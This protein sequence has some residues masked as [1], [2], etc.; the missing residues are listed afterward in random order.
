MDSRNVADDLEPAGFYRTE[1]PDIVNPSLK[2]RIGEKASAAIMPLIK[3]AARPYLGGGTIADAL[4]VAA[5]LRGDGLATAF[6]YWDGGRESLAEIETVSLAAI[7]ALAGAARE[8]YLSLKP[9]ALRFSIATA[10]RLATAAAPLALR[11]HFDAHGVEVAD[12]QNAMLEAMLETLG[13]DRLGTTLPGRQHRSLGDADRAVER[14]LNVRVVKGEWPDPADP[15]RDLRVGFLEVIARL[16]GRAR[17]VSVA[18][19]DFA[20]GRE[21][22]ERLRAA[23]TPCEIEVLLGMPAK[24]LTDWAKA[25]AVTVRVYVPYGC[26]FIPNAVGVLRRNPRLVLAI[27]KA[28]IAQLTA[29]VLRRGALQ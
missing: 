28:Q 22:I 6:S 13:S 16:A 23:G 8:S 15:K 26:G 7:A 1:P 3:R 12:R 19:H 27:A 14:G 21:A 17:R 20:L 18:T 11:L 4:C 5:R 24:P 29:M 2:R 9:P 25:N 10:R